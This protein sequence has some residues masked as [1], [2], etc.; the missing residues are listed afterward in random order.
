MKKDAP[1]LLQSDA[2]PRVA[3]RIR[4]FSEA[5]TEWAADGW[6]PASPPKAV[7]VQAHC[8]EYS[9]FGATVQKKALAA[10]CIRDVREATGCCGVAVN[11]G[12]EASHY[13]VSMKVAEQALIPALE[14]TRA[15]TPVLTDG[16]SCSMQIKQLEPE[17][18]SL[19]IAEI[20]DPER[21]TE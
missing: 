15:D 7:T 4:S 19:H 9:V 3:S 12:F 20:L 5:V 16:F 18:K 13:G 14:R 8:H 2:A 6:H 21:P 1:E 10:A 17:R 11:F